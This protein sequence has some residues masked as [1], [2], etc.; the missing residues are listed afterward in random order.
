MS[1]IF[2]FKRILFVVVLCMSVVFAFGCKGAEVDQALD[3]SYKPEIDP[4]NFVDVIDHMYMP[5]TV[6]TVLI[7]EGD[8]GDGR[9]HVETHVTGE[10][11]EVMGVQCTVVRDR[12]WVDGELEEDTYDWF[13]QD[14][15]GNVWYFGEDS[16]EIEDGEVISTEGSWEAGVDGAQPGIIMKAEPQIG[17]SYRQEYYFGEAEDMAE[18]M[19]IVESVAIEYETFTNVLK[20]KEWTPLESGVAENKYYAIGIGLILEEVAEGGEGRIELIEI[21]KK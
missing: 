12:V 20:T 17:M 6:G 18:V 7:Y 1:N 10:K 11:K 5:L 4:E 3:T 16:K 19:G 8:T 13:A 15:E 21:N 2:K 14:K 9:E